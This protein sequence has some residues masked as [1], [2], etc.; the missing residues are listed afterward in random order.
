MEMMRNLR[1]VN[2]DHLHVG[3]YQSTYFGG[4]INRS[5]LDSQF[6]YQ[7]SIDESVVL[8]YGK[9]H[10]APFIFIWFYQ[11]YSLCYWSCT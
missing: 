9:F 3:W 11:M 1:K 4:S 5:L 6:N 2:I 10:D 7:H 8:I